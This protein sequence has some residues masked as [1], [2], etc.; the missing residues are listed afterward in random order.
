MNVPDLNRTD[1]VC[2]LWLK[3]GAIYCLYSLETCFQVVK[4]V[5]DYLSM[6]PVEM[7]PDSIPS[8]LIEVESWK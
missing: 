7:L 6:F 1:Q 3:K 2:S 4:R 8:D 5:C